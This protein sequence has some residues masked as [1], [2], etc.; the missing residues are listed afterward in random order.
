MWVCSDVSFLLKP[1]ADQSVVTAGP[2]AA[3]DSSSQ[4]V[5]PKEKALSSTAA[6]RLQQELSSSECAGSRLRNAKVQTALLPL[7]EAARCDQQAGPCVN[8][9]TQ[10]KKSGKS[11]QMRHRTQQ[12]PSTH[13]GQPPPAAGSELSAPHI[14][15]TDRK[16]VV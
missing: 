4:V 12:P 16:S 5:R 9:G 15:D 8:R 10:T 1:G 14:R 11:G 3:S 13:C 6:H 7:N 2:A